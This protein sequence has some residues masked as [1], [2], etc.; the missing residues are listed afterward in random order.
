MPERDRNL[1]IQ[2]RFLSRSR[3]VRVSVDNPASGTPLVGSSDY[4]NFMSLPLTHKLYV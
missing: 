1:F 3:I 4:G 2:I